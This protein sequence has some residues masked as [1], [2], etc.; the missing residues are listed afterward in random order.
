MQLKKT[1][2][3]FFVKILI[4]S[5]GIQLRELHMQY[6]LY[7]QA[8]VKAEECWFLVALLRSFEHLAFDRTFDKQNS[9]FEFFV[10]ADN[11]ATFK[12]IMHYLEQVGI[13]S[14]VQQLPNRLV[15]PHAAV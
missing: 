6:G 15:D 8:H 5:R 1:R 9:V 3:P 10:P 2:G 4:Q 7:Y 11:E 14:D 12:E 13:V